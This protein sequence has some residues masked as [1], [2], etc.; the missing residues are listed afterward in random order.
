METKHFLIYNYNKKSNAH[1]NS[2]D[3]NLNY[4]FT[5]SLIEQNCRNI[6]TDTRSQYKYSDQITEHD[7]ARVIK[8]LPNRKSCGPVLV[9]AEYF[10]NEVVIKYII[11]LLIDVLII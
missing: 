10:K 8:S 4:F 2:H 6:D 7:V 3:T 11:K 1:I 5:Y 9:Y